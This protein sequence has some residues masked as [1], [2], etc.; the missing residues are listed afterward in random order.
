M[1]QKINVF[2]KNHIKGK[3]A[4]CPSWPCRPGQQVQGTGECLSESSMIDHLSLLR[5]YLLCSLLD[6]GRANKANWQN[7]FM[8]RERTNAKRMTWQYKWLQLE[9]TWQYKWLQLEMEEA[10]AQRIRPLN[11]EGMDTDQLRDRVQVIFWSAV[12]VLICC[13]LSSYFRSLSLLLSMN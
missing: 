1:G 11:L 8:D 5:P 10:L 4:W 9:M 13:F 7:V 6:W 2:D 12:L 3:E